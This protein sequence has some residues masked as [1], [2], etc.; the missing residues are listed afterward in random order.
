MIRHLASAAVA[1][2]SSL[3]GDFHYVRLWFYVLGGAG[4]VAIVYLFTLPIELPMWPG[5]IFDGLA[6]LLGLAWEKHAD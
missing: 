1:L 6:G 2:V 5:F 3:I 4:I